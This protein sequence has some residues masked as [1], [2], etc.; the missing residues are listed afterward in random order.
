MLIYYVNLCVA[1]ISIDNNY[2]NANEKSPRISRNFA[3]PSTK[4]FSDKSPRIGR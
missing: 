3:R 2:V 1:I 4:T